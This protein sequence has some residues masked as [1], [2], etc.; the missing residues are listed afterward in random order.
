MNRYLGAQLTESA[1][2]T[3][4]TAVA[5][6]KKTLVNILLGNHT[7]TD[8]KC[9]IQIEDGQDPAVVIW[10]AKDVQIL[11]AEPVTELKGLPLVA[12]DKIKIRPHTED[13]SALVFGFEEA[14]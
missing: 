7:G 3:S 5:N 6:G 1:N 13:I 11:A 2:W 4:A 8:A 12:G 14:V 10:E 9:D